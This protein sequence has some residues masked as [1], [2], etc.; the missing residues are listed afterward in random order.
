MH[1]EFTMR[2][3]CKLLVILTPAIFFCG[4]SAQRLEDPLA[5]STNTTFTVASLSPQAQKLYLERRVRIA[6]A[7]TQLLAEMIAKDVLDLES[8]ELNSTSQKLLA[9][10][11]AK[12]AQPTAAEIKKIYDANSATLGGR[13]IEQVREQIV[14]FLKHESE[15]KLTDA[16]VQTLRAKY[17][18]AL[19]KDVNAVGLGP[20]EAVATVGGRAITLAELDQANKV[21]LNDIE[22]EILEVLRSNL[23]ASILSALATEEAKERKLDTSAYI[24]AEITDKLRLFTDDERAN[25]EDALRRRLFAKYSV[26]VTLPEPVRVVQNI[27]IE[28]DDPQIGNAAAPVTVVMFT[29]FQ[30]PACAATHPVLK[31]TLAQYGDKVR[32][33]VRD[34]PLETI[35]KEAFQAAVAANAA[36]AQGKFF[37]YAEILYRNQEA[38]DKPSLTR[39]AAE[40]GLNA[41]QFELDFSDARMGSEVRKDQADGRSHGVNS[42]PTIYVNGAKVHRLSAIAF[43]RAIERALSK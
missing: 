10:Q 24:A 35:H 30:C 16:Y 4:V 37:E 20:S 42:T 39:Y 7:R 23:E 3:F 13:T 27:A 19:G 22:V 5:T 15:E 43:R 14:D 11:R 32:L 18:V 9:A 28:A 2:Y 41:K 29:D 26:K 36:R 33:V 38:L 31:Q 34:F 40:L 21:R 12:A 8:K 6:E 25:V 17:K 1:Y